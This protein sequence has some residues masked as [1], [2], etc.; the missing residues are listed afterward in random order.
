MEAWHS[1]NDYTFNVS[2]GKDLKVNCRLRWYKKQMGLDPL[3]NLKFIFLS[4]FH[5]S[6]P[7]ELTYFLVCWD[8]FLL[9]FMGYES[10]ILTC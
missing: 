10:S 1:W 5:P 2:V 7:A 3:K 6:L 8:G 9:L 4:H